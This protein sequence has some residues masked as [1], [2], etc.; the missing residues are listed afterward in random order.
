MVQ[1]FSSSDYELRQLLRMVK[2]VTSGFV[3]EDEFGEAFRNF[4]RG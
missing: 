2:P 4:A 1:V 3:G